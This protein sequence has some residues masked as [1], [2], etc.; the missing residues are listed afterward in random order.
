[1]PSG[2]PS[3]INKK[4]K[5]KSIAGSKMIKSASKAKTRQIPPSLAKIA[6]ML[7]DINPDKRIT[8]TE[9][10]SNNSYFNSTWRK[11]YEEELHVI[12]WT[13]TQILDNSGKAKWIL[14][15]LVQISIV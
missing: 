9:L 4:K 3:A 1:M 13:E 6:K 10:V 5:P 12:D 2:P 8:L 14:N 7:Q 15:D 11:Q